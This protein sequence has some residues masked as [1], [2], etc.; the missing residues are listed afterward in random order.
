[1]CTLHIPQNERE[2]IRTAVEFT[3]ILVFNGE[4]D[5]II[6]KTPIYFCLSTVLARLCSVC[7]TLIYHNI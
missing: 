3:E 4:R 2:F 5:N 6:L 7:K 1:M